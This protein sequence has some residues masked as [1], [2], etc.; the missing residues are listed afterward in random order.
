MIILVLALILLGS[1]TAATM[2]LLKGAS[3]GAVILAYMAGGWAGLLLGLLL[4]ICRKSSAG[5][6]R[7]DMMA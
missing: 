6:C 5:L 1:F 4:R 3:W 2:F 7:K